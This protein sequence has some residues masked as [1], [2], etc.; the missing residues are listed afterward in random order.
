MIIDNK[1]SGLE[2]GI[3]DFYNHKYFIDYVFGQSQGMCIVRGG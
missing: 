3:Y 1:F 2:I